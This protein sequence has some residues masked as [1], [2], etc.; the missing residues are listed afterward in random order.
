MAELRTRLTFDGSVDHVENDLVPRVVVTLVQ[1]NG[2][3]FPVP[4]DEGNGGSGNEIASRIKNV[5]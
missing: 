1:R 3:T 5:F 2:K 4:L